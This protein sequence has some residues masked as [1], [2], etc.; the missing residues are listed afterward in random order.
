MVWH[1]SLKTKT[2]EINT[3]VENKCVREK[4]RGEGEREIIKTQ[5]TINKYLD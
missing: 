4:E 1:N 3:H 2:N 5:Q